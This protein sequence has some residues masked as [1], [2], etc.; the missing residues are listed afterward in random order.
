MW[1][2]L[3]KLWGIKHLNFR[4]Q[5][6]FALPS[7]LWSSSTGLVCSKKIRAFSYARDILLIF[8][9]ML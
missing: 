1:W 2:Y 5:E 6:C 7:F 4:V 8:P 3:P 9:F